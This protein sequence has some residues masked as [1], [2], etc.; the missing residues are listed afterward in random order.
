MLACVEAANTPEQACP[1]DGGRTVCPENWEMRTVYLVEAIPKH[2]A[3]GRDVARRVLYVDSES[4]VITA[5]DQWDHLG[6]MWKTQA[7]FHAY[8]DRSMPEAHEAVY[9]FK[10]IFTTAIV[11]E[12][13]RTGFSSVSYLPGGE[14]DEHEGW[15]IDAGSVSAS[16]IAAA[17]ATA[18][19]RQSGNTR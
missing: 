3:H 12:D 16:S 6:A 15:Y 18:V 9:P 11:D 14:A 1:A 10:R 4:W 19:N 7:L 17:A 8:R 13:L 5:A 2:H